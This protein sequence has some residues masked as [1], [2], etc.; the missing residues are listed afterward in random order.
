M[1]DKCDWYVVHLRHHAPVYK[2]KCG[3]A[4]EMDLGCGRAVE[5][6]GRRDKMSERA[7]VANKTKEK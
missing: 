3:W 4:E 6:K 1:I 7:G 5:G 2:I